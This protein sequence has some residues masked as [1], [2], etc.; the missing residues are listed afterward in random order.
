S[1]GKRRTLIL[2]TAAATALGIAALFVAMRGR[3]PAPPIAIPTEPPSQST[4]SVAN[5]SPT[6]PNPKQ[7]EPA[8]GLAA[9][10]EAPSAGSPSASPKSGPEA[11]AAVAAPAPEPVRNAAASAPAKAKAVPEVK[12]RISAPAGGSTETRGGTGS[13]SPR[14]TRILEKAALGEPLAPDEK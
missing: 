10:A 14:C 4:G 9:N 5:S 2:A 8:A 3:E 11:S 6:K 7:D 13:S 12:S 1:G